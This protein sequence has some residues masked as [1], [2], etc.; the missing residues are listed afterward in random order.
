MTLT[1][2][3]TNNENVESRRIF[4]KSIRYYFRE[5]ATCSSIH[6]F[7]YFGEKRTYL[8]RIWWFI[9]FSTVFAICV[10]QIKEVY[11]KWEIS[12][13][14]VSF[15]T[16]ETPIHSIPFP[17]VT[18]CP[19]SKSNQSLYNHTDIIVKIQEAK[20]RNLD[21]NLTDAQQTHALY[22]SMIC[23]IN[24][25][26][27]K[28]M[29]TFPEDFYT[30]LDEVNSKNI[31][32]SCSWMGEQLSPCE[33]YFIPIITDEGICYTFNMLDRE[34][35]FRDTV[36]HHSN[37]L[38]N[39][40]RQKLT[41]NLDKGYLDYKTNS[42]PK[43]AKFPGVNNAL[44]VTM[45]THK[46]DMDPLCKNSLQGFRVVLHIPLRIPRPKNQ[47][48]R[49]PLNEA[50]LGQ[51]QP[52]M[53]STSEAV[54]VYH[55]KRR[56]CYFPNERYLK[57]FKIYTQNNC[58]LECLTN[59][60]L[61]R[62]NCV[63]FFMPRENGTV[64]CGASRKPCMILVEKFL[65]VTDLVRSIDELV[66]SKSKSKSANKTESIEEQ[67]RNKRQ[68]NDKAPHCDCMPICSDLSYAV[69]T[70]QVKW[71]WKEKFSVLHPRTNTEKMHMSKLVL[72]FRQSQFVTSKRHELY[73]PTDFLANFGGLL[74]LFTGFSVLSIME[75]IYF[76]TIRLCCNVSLYGR[77]TVMV[78]FLTG[79]SDSK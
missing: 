8:E 7:R 53:M 4:C 71:D 15:D 39:P 27:G 47:Y 61:D 12:P 9:V 43:R 35:L 64:I 13:V 46:N 14:I 78:T 6:G 31:F 79:T 76:L 69:E 18:I 17:A 36:I 30:F 50:V 59:F 51:I 70:S 38:I 40:Y 5:Y 54:Q 57:Y 1:E 75:I 20:R 77:C 48:F 24:K 37:F 65:Q 11:H 22:M 68:A 3:V 21:L 28:T 26:V 63:N 56:Q 55:P 33:D 45:V 44:E 10:Y 19:E 29:H 67:N 74:G 72:Y 66:K 34:D 25:R 58:Q 60:T 42:Y 41:W 52:Q 73:G 16:S 23:D 2:P 49:V 62:C 32:R